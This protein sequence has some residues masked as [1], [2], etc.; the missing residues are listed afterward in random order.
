L[1]ITFDFSLYLQSTTVLFVDLDSVVLKNLD[2][3]F[4]FP[5]LTVSNDQAEVRHSTLQQTIKV[6]FI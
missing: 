3:L 1:A 2:F 6:I 5:E 4:S